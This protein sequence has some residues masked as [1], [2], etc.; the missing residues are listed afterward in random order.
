[1]TKYFIVF[2]LCVYPT[3]SFACSKYLRSDGGLSTQCDG[4]QDVPL[5]L[6]GHC[7]FSELTVPSNSIGPIE[8]EVCVTK[9]EYVLSFKQAVRKRY[10]Q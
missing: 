6:N 9:G 1:M 2:L 8:T 10:G 5:N 3:S 7:A 4:T